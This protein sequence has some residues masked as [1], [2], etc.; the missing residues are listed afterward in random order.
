[1]SNENDKKTTKF[2]I[3]KNQFVPYWNMFGS[4]NAGFPNSVVVGRGAIGSKPI[5]KNP[6][7]YN[8]FMIFYA[9]KNIF[10]LNQHFTVF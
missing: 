2:Q 10:Y 1:M 7:N 4:P 3:I 6:I 9:T 5:Y 8:Y